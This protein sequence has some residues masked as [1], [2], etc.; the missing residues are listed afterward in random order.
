[1]AASAKLYKRKPLKG[2]PFPFPP[3]QKKKNRSIIFDR[4]YRK[5]DEVLTRNHTRYEDH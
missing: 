2:V 1:L 5:E 4:L 3:S